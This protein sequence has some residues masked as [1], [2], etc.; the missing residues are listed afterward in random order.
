MCAAKEVEM[1]MMVR[2]NLKTVSGLFDSIKIYIKDFEGVEESYFVIIADNR[3]NLD[4]AV[5]LRSNVQTL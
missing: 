4:S 3:K 5:L 2:E 1:E